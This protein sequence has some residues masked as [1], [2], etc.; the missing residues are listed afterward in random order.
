MNFPQDI[1][2]A[3]S[4]EWIR[5]NSDGTGTVGITDYAQSE[6]GDVVFVDAPNP[7]KTLD[8]GD[9][10]GTIEA[11]KTVSDLYAPVGGEIVAVNGTIIDNPEIINKDPYGDGWIVKIQ[12][13][14]PSQ[15]DG[16][17]DAAQYQ[18]MIGQGH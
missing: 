14:D 2:Y 11:V 9:V 4:H 17:M 7:G 15:L 8:T 18:E 10:L 1:R 5:V 16:M 3:R 12:L 6:L 13:T